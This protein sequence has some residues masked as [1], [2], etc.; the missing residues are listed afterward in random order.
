[1]NPMIYLIVYFLLG[2]RSLVLL[3]TAISSNGQDMATKQA[4]TFNGPKARIAVADQDILICQR[5]VRKTGPGFVSQ[6]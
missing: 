3:A 6:V 5:I 4:E 2:I 1:M